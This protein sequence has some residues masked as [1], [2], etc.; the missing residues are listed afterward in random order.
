[1]KNSIKITL[2]G[3]LLTVCLA[4]SVSCSKKGD[5]NPDTE[6]LTEKQADVYV[7]GYS[8]GKGMYWKNGE[9]VPVPDGM[10]PRDLFVSGQD[11]YI[12][13]AKSAG[14]QKT[15][16]LYLKNGTETE[17][18]D[19]TTKVIVSSMF[20]DKTAVYVA[21][22]EIDLE[23]GIPSAVYWKNTEKHKL[24]GRIFR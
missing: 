19:G 16:A 18:S 6:E 15:I 21:G 3:T 5:N 13:G 2:L 8:H 14:G 17:L 1:M 23:T 7:V 11:L 9:A 4:V 20:V 12:A 22:M 10:D 24:S